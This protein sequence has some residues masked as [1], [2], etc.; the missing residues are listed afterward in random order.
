MHLT[1]ECL[2][3]Y[4]NASSGEKSGLRDLRPVWILQSIYH[5]HS[6]GRVGGHLSSEEETLQK[7]DDASSDAGKYLVFHYGLRRRSVS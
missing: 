5:R 7:D 2:K 6:S 3:E 1:N 4:L